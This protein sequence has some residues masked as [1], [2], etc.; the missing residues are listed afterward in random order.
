MEIEFIQKSS[1]FLSLGVETLNNAV[2]SLRSFICFLQMRKKNAT[3]II[4]VFQIQTFI[5]LIFFVSFEDSTVACFDSL[6]IY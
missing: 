4:L 2:K 1:S 6:P 3:E 5:F